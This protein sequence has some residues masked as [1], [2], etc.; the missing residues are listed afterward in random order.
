MARK[1]IYY[2][3]SG[4][5][6]R[7]EGKMYH[8]L[9]MSASQAEWWAI[10]AGLAMARNGVE[11]PENFSDMGMAAMATTGL[12]LV[13]KIPAEE[14]KP[15]LEELMACVQSVPNPADKKVERP[16]IETDTEEVITRL[17][18]RAEVFKLHVDFLQNV[19]R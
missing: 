5:K 13:A 4:T 12:S 8:I 15:L 14:A 9:E 18:L 10:R 7:D 17:K 16:L 19:A 11:L 6:G 3:V 1:E 2:T